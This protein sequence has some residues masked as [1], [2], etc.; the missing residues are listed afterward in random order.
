M[1]YSGYDPDK[2][3]LEIGVSDCG[4]GCKI[5]RDSDSNTTFVMHSPTYG[6]KLPSYIPYLLTTDDPYC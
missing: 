2:E 3:Y 4:F 1:A 6:C 5:Y